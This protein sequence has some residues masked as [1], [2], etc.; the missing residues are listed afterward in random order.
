ME[1]CPKQLFF[2]KAIMN[3]F[4]D[5]T[6]LHVNYHKSN[7]YSINVPNKKMDFC[8]DISLLDWEIPLHLSRTTDGPHQTK[9]RNILATDPKDRMVLVNNYPIPVIGWLTTE[10]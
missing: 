3:S 10:G 7:I 9:T 8:Q 1:A 4:T 6:T 5:S 2:L